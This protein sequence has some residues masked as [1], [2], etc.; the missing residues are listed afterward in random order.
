MTNQWVVDIPYNKPSSHYE[1]MVGDEIERLTD[2]EGKVW[3]K[4]K[5]SLFDSQCNILLKDVWFS[6]DEISFEMI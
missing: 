5:L 2:S 6:E 3:V 4:L 1:G